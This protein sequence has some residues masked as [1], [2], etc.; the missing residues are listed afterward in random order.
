MELSESDRILNWLKAGICQAP[1]SLTEMFYFDSSKNL[2][3]SLLATDYMMLDE[4]LNFA[5]GLQSTYSDRE[6][7]EL[8]QFIRKVEGKDPN[9]INIPRLTE[10]ERI[11]LLDDFLAQVSSTEEVEQ[12]LED[13]KLGIKSKFN[14]KF[15]VNGSE[16]TKELWFFHS[17]E[18]LHSKAISFIESNGILIDNCSIWDVQPQ[19]SFTIKIDQ[20]KATSEPPEKSEDKKWWQFWK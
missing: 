1:N 9:I 14:R 17:Q 3:F 8:L 19:G 10:A 4:D 18:L 11:E 20:E 16:R 2:F 6:A 7:E 15:E 13:S 5:D 12:I